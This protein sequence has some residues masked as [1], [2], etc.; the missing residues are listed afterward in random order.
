MG[1]YLAFRLKYENPS[2]P[3]SYKYAKISSL[4]SSITISARIFDD[5]HAE[6]KTMTVRINF[7]HI[8]AKYQACHF[9]LLKLPKNS[10]VFTLHQ[11]ANS[12]ASVFLRISILLLQQTLLS[13]PLFPAVKITIT[14]WIIKLWFR[15]NAS[16]NARQLP[17]YMQ[18]LTLS[19]IPTNSILNKLFRS[20]RLY[21]WT[22]FCKN[23]FFLIKR[24]FCWI[25]FYR[26]KSLHVSL[27]CF[28][29]S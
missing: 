14:L 8:T 5:Q 6:L 13:L 1:A 9:G 25:L 23:K 2:C 18:L 16:W 12:P 19:K 3:K 17:I 27:T 15:Q 20:N 4:C 10:P 24:L 22:L 29:L 7:D 21:C 11:T 26:N 28:A